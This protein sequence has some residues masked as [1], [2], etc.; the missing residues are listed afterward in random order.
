MGW[1]GV[2]DR[3]DVRGMWL[4][5]SWRADTPGPRGWAGE[6]GG[7]GGGDEGGGGGLWGQVCGRSPSCLCSLLQQAWDTAGRW[8]DLYSSP[9]VIICRPACLCVCV[10]V[11]A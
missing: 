11:C 5:I 2:V 7:G 3:W 1:S 4:S 10:C 9:T 8:A 6:G